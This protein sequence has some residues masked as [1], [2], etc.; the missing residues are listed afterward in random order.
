[1]ELSSHL[2]LEDNLDVDEKH[3]SDAKQAFH[4]H[5]LGETVSQ[6]LSSKGVED[7]SEAKEGG[8]R[9]K[10]PLDTISESKHDAI[11]DDYKE[12]A[13]GKSNYSA[14]R[15]TLTC[16]AP[17]GSPLQGKRAT[18]GE[19]ELQSL[20]SPPNQ[21]KASSSTAVEQQSVGSILM[22]FPCL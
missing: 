10:S 18:F 6:G 8:G 22:P 4:A 16:C 21:V 3:Y 12:E 2:T 11:E 7:K 17:D 9:L 19:I 14:R 15:C 13:R 20:Q 1:M 5:N